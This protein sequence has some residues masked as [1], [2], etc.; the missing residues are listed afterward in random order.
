[1][2]EHPTR[3]FGSGHVL[4][5]RGLKPRIRLHADGAESAWDSLC[6]S[7]APSPSFSLSKYTTKLQKI[8]TF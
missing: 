2:V 1:M 6:P 5:V 4:A 3:D 8:I 7:P